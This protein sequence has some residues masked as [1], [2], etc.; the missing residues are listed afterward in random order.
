VVVGPLDQLSQ[1]LRVDPFCSDADTDAG[2]E[3]PGR[4]SL[5]HAEK[6]AVVRF[7]IDG[8]LKAL[9]PHAEFCSTRS[10]DSGV[11]AGLSRSGAT[12][13]RELN[14]HHP[15]PLACP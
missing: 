3:R 2:A 7:A 14:P 5:I 9:K 13:A 12:P 6:A 1:A 11:A 4:H 15:H 10:D 8:D